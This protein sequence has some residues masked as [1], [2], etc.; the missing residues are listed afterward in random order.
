MRS[1][2]VFT[3]PDG[4]GFYRVTRVYQRR[5]Q[6]Q[7]QEITLPIQ[8]VVEL[9]DNIYEPYSNYATFALLEWQQRYG[10]GTSISA[11]KDLQ[12]I[13]GHPEF[14]VLDAAS[15][16]YDRLHKLTGSQDLDSNVN[17]D[18]GWK[19]TT[20]TI[21][22][23][24]SFMTDAPASSV[25]ITVDF[26]YRPLVDVLKSVFASRTECRNIVFV[27]YEQRVRLP[28]GKDMGVYSEAFCSKR[29]RDFYDAIQRY[30]GD[31]LER[32]VAGLIFSSD[33]LA[34]TN[35]GTT[36]IWPIYLSVANMTTK[37]RTGRDSRGIYHI[38]HIPEVNSSPSY[39]QHL[40]LTSSR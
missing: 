33:A 5:H 30:P 3:E 26:Y 8:P 35:F 13:M 16:N 29:F 31:D 14:R 10:S 39:R 12:S 22:V 34:P 24:L 11:M 38:A 18:A 2:L 40:L 37:E 17:Y 7:T 36:K 15:F 27:P 20:L 25:P 21:D 19:T 23:L 1:T 32:T 6:A 28:S 4:F 9:P